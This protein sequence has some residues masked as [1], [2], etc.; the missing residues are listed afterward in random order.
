[1]QLDFL[2]G[3]VLPAQLYHKAQKVREVMRSQLFEIFQKVDVLALPSSSEPAPPVMKEAG[4][5]SKEE[6]TAR[7]S[8][9][10]SLT[11]MANLASIPALSVPCGFASVGGKDLP[12]GLQLMGRAHEDA[13]L[14]RTA[15]A[16]EQNTPWHTRRPPI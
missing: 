7:M 6:A 2:V 10:R 14:L 1:M 3:A 8:G 15:H 4:L 12:V 13:L 9:R 11:G 16:Y 5:K